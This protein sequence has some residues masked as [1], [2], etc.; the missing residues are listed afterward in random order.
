M[1]SLL[2]VT[3][4][5]LLV[6]IVAALFGFGVVTGFSMESARIL[7]WVAIMLFLISLVANLVSKPRL[8]R[9]GSY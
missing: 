8:D 6:A 3:I 5:F 9:D 2:Y 1:R 4:A 7:F